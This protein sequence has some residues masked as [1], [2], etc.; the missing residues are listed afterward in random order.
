MGDTITNKSD[1]NDIEMREVNVVLE[2]RMQDAMS[3]DVLDANSDDVLDAVQEQGAEIALGPTVSL[4]TRT[5][6]ILLRFDVLAENDAGIYRKVAEAIE[7][8]EAHT[9]LRF[10][11]SHMA[12]DTGAEPVGGTLAAC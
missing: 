11:S 12:L 6:S 4:N 3:E 1:N 8:I 7:I 5:S 2:L 9:D 10:V